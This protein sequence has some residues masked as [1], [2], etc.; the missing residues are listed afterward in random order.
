M[1]KFAYTFDFGIKP[2]FIIDAWFKKAFLP[3]FI[4]SIILFPL[5]AFTLHNIT[6]FIIPSIAVGAIIIFVGVYV[7]RRH[8]A[9]RRVKNISNKVFSYEIDSQGIHFHNDLGDGVLKWGFKGKLIPFKKFIL[10]QSNEIGL[11][12]LPI[13]TPPEILT[14]M[15]SKLRSNKSLKKETP[16]SG[17]S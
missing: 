10:L 15:E 7:Y 11:I 9:I 4:I 12:P 5:C 13:D 2:A 14:L 16:Q 6:K 1:D 17:A 8:L 3:V